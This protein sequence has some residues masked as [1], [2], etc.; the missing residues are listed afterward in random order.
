M[1][2]VEQEILKKTHM[3]D[4]KTFL[5]EEIIKTLEYEYASRYLESLKLQPTPA[6]IKTIIDKHPL[7]GCEIQ[8]TGWDN[9][10]DMVDTVMVYPHRTGKNA[11]NFN[12]FIRDKLFKSMKDD[13]KLGRRAS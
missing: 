2:K 8:T 12:R 3:I 4:R 7:S 9:I 5:T 10:T 6:N 11:R 13:N 1:T